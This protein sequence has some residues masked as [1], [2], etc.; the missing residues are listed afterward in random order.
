MKKFALILAIFSFAVVGP[1]FA[2]AGPSTTDVIPIVDLQLGGLIGGVKDRGWVK[3]G[4]FA[5]LLEPKLNFKLFGADG[6]LENE[7][8]AA[9]LIEPDVPCDEYYGV[10]FDT[11]LESGA[12]IGS[13]AG[14][15]LFPRAS[16]KIFPTNS[17]YE[18]IVR[19]FLKKKGIRNTTIKIEQGFLVDLDGDMQDEAVIAATFYRDGLSPS[20][21]K[22][23]YSFVL[24]R[25]I[26]G[27][28]VKEILL[29]GDFIKKDLEFGAP[30][31][32]HISAIADFNGDGNMEI[33]VFS[34]YYEGASAGIF[35]IKQDESEMVLD[36]G[37]GV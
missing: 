23:D 12:A 14:W 26:V 37:C 13:A 4:G 11:E 24:V 22:G 18:R 30:S 3:T 9:N 35:V 2:A 20:A 7:L 32:Y 10:R 1:A 21:V 17:S 27:K 5:S 6:K 8:R 16:R 19:T 36:A 31:E 29:G 15:N 33:A 25:K 34:Q 28:S